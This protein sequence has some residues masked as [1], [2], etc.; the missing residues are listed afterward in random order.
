[1]DSKTLDKMTPTLKNCVASKT[2]SLTDY[3]KDYEIG[4]QKG[5]S[6][7]CSTEAAYNQSWSIRL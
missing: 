6:E 3:T 7:L 5:L 1:M 4:F 2:Y